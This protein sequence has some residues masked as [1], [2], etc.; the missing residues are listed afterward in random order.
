MG[1]RWAT[2]VIGLGLLLAPLAAGYA[3]AAAILRDVSTA[4][5]V[6]VTALASMQWPRVRLLNVLTALW[7]FHSARRTAD[8]RAAS[9][10]LAAGALLLAA[11]LL[12]HRRRVTSAPAPQRA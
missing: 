8:A 2:F 12:P 3:S 1:S 9:V 10:E 4:T 5:L 7:L 11:A 6:C